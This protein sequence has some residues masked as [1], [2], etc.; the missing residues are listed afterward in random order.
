MTKATLERQEILDKEMEKLSQSQDSNISMP[1]P[2]SPLVRR[3]NPSTPS[4]LHE[5]VPMRECLAT[6]HHLFS[7]SSTN[8]QPRYQDLLDY[9]SVKS[10][11]SCN[12]DLYVQSPGQPPATPLPVSSPPAAAPASFHP[13]P[14]LPSPVVSQSPSLSSPAERT[15][16]LTNRVPAQSKGQSAGN[17][18]IP[19]IKT[20]TLVKFRNTPPVPSPTNVTKGPWRANPL[21]KEPFYPKVKVQNDPQ[22]REMVFGKKCDVINLELKPLLDSQEPPKKKIKRDTSLKPE[23]QKIK[24]IVC[25]ECGT[26]LNTLADIK[27]HSC[28]PEVEC[29]DCLPKKTV[30]ANKKVLRE[31]L[32][33]MHPQRG[34]KHFCHLC[35]K[36]FYHKTLQT[37]HLKSKHT[38]EY[39][40][41]LAEQTGEIS[42]SPSD[43]D[44]SPSPVPEQEQSVLGEGDVQQEQEQSVLGEGNVQQEQEQS[45]L[46]KGDVQKEQEQSVLGEGDVQQEQEHSLE[47]DVPQEQEHSFKGIPQKEQDFLERNV[48]P[49]QSVE[50]EDVEQEREVDSSVEIEAEP[51]VVANIE[52]VKEYIKEVHKRDTKNKEVIASSFDEDIDAPDSVV[53]EAEKKKP[54]SCSRCQKG[55]NTSLRYQNHRKHC[56]GV[57]GPDRN[58]NLQVVTK[59]IKP[60]RYVAAQAGWSDVMTKQRCGKCGRNNYHQ[61]S[62]VRHL[63]TCRGTLMDNNG[64]RFECFYC[65]EPKRIFNT[66]NSMRR[67]VA[68]SHSKEAVEDGWDYA[69]IPIKSLGLASNHLFR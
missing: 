17:F 51:V 31:H 34:E 49:E 47:G 43:I 5:P 46:G 53:S 41:Q 64:K 9:P 62:L 30:L 12:L 69:S 26:G 15:H 29:E 33:L 42:P 52:P 63:P 38:L 68:T 65:Q 2:V 39:I 60:V 21:P 13:V 14:Y 36:S 7:P 44:M 25:T 61:E 48:S 50:I 6:P 40:E 19:T 10:V 54:F 23:P 59:V 1:P 32:K 56:Q 18:E 57:A 45:V 55:F 8:A 11:N 4:L 22:T 20:Q 3:R 28:N 35:D 58:D 67:H 37:L 66:E 16:E 27:N 24:R